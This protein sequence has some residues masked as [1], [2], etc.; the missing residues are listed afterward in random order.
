MFFTQIIC[1]A[2][3]GWELFRYA[4]LYIGYA[5]PPETAFGSITYLTIL[6]ISAPG[7]IM[8]PAFFFLGLYPG[9]YRQYL[10]LITLGKLLSIFGGSLYLVAGRQE[11]SLGYLL[12]P[13]LNPEYSFGVLIVVV[14]LILL[15]FLLS[16]KGT[17]ED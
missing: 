11:F 15:V 2:A 6:W 7:T 3:A 13:E 14:D 17:P 9:R 10:N 5:V 8:A 16:L 12:N 1:L 4:V